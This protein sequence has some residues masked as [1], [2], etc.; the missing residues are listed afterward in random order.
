M[1]KN[2]IS[3]IIGIA[4]IFAAYDSAFVVT[5]VEQV[6]ITQFGKPIGDS[7]KKPGLKFKI[8]FIQKVNTFEKR[9]IQWDGDPNEI[10]TSDKT[11]IW[12]DANARWR[13]KDPLVFMQRIGSTARAG[14]VLNNLINGS[15]RDLITKS[16]LIEVII[17]SDWKEEYLLT[18]EKSRL[19]E[20]RNIKVGRDKFSDLIVKNIKNE[21]SKNGI[22][23]ADVLIKRL[24]YTEKV[25][26]RVFDRMISERN[27]I[28]AELRS[29]GEGLKS[30]ILG[31]MQKKLS[32]IESD[33]SR[34]A[35][36]IKGTS[37]AEAIKISGLAYSKDPEFYQF[38]T[39]LQSYE[40]VLGKNTRLVIDINSDLYKFLS[41]S[42]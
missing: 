34:K 31:A 28:A 24:N 15:L 18:T 10:P 8:P 39:T 21:M 37:D 16:N 26:R 25:Q 3:S 4:I 41:R 32:S 6:V 17:S 7:I 22:E 1:N 5:E 14:L 40:E 19:A 35:E 29:Q 30:E 27:R 9:Y 42:K 11:F 2:I 23:V 38:W 20:R 13:I 33:A 36:E 12:V